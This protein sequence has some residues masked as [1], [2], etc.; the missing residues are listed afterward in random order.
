MARHL[1]MYTPAG[2]G[3]TPGLVKVIHG[4]WREGR[5]MIR[6]LGRLLRSRE[7]NRG[8]T[9]I[10]LLIVILIVGILTAVATPLY[11]GYIKDARTAEAKAVA[12]S[13]WSAVQSNTIANCGTAASIANAYPKA[14]LTPAGA[15][16]PARWTVA[17]GGDVT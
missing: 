1:L 6:A 4:D 7:S 13:L 8:F 14:G 11:L 12:G 17:A 16:T 15:T 5:D 9:L 2:T 10:E 3:I